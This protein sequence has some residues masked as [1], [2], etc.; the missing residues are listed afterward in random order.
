M[1]CMQA[2][3]I[4]AEGVGIRTAL[5]HPDFDEWADA[6]EWESGI[7]MSSTFKD[8][9]GR[10]TPACLASG[11]RFHFFFY[12]GCPLLTQMSW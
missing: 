1:A 10:R 5:V 12:V 2:M 9:D 6:D 8:Y 4:V 3:Q 7:G 11:M